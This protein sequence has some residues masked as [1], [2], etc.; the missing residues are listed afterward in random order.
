[1]DSLDSFIRR[2][3]EV[4]GNVGNFTILFVCFTQFCVIFAAMLRL[5]VAFSGTFSVFS[6][7]QNRNTLFQIILQHYP[8][9]VLG[10][11]ALHFPT[12]FGRDEVP[13]SPSISA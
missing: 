5:V 11:L 3:F 9:Q 1:M 10:F 2:M 4:M 7:F 6:L 13:E 12:H 8:L